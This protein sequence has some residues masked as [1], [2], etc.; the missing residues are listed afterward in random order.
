[1]FRA[2]Q[3]Q[4]GE[5]TNIEFQKDVLLGKEKAESVSTLIEDF[6]T[7]GSINH[8]DLGNHYSHADLTSDHRMYTVTYIHL[9]CC[10]IP[11]HLHGH[12]NKSWPRKL[13]N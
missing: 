8:D 3:L 7:E 2:H 9:L 10:Y 6:K 13:N 4:I 12:R 11:T 1:M 5:N